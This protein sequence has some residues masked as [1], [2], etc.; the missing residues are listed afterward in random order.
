MIRWVVLTRLG[1]GIAPALQ[2]GRSDTA[3][4]RFLSKRVPNEGASQSPAFFS[5]IGPLSTKFTKR[6]EIPRETVWVRKLVIAIEKKTVK[7]VVEREI[8][9]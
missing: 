6:N 7:E 4:E 1:G 5:A 3:G 2:P 9:F 8:F